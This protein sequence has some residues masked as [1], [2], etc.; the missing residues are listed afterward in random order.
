MPPQELAQ[1][2]EFRSLWAERVN[3]EHS[4]DEFS[5]LCESFAT[6]ARTMA[7]SLS[8]PMAPAPAAASNPP[9][10]PRPPP[11]RPPHA[12]GFRPFNPIAARRLQGLYRHSNKRA[13]RQLLCDTAVQYSGSLPQA[14]TYFE[15]VLAEKTCNT[16]ATNSV[17]F[18]NLPNVYER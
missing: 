14:E 2:T 17:Y 4:W 3:S 11:R 1:L 10:P 15:S 8:N 13:A 18:R 5:Q 7:Q 12:R 9:P 6:E 16:T